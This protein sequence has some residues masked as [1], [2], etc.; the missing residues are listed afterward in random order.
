[1]NLFKRLIFLLPLLYLICSCQSNTSKQST[2]TKALLKHS[3]IQDSTKSNALKIAYVGNMGV[4]I[5]YDDNTVIIDGL[6]Q[7]YNKAYVHPTQDMVD[8]L[9]S[10]NFKNFTAIEY[11]LITHIHG[12]HFSGKYAKQYLEQNTNG[13]VVGSSQIKNDIVDFHSKKDSLIQRLIVVPY[14]KKPHVIENSNISITAIQCNHSSPKRHRNTQNFAYLVEINDFNVL[15]VGDTDWDLTREPMTTLGLKAKQIDIAVLPYWLLL[16]NDA[17]E[18]VENQIAPRH[19]IASH[20]PPDFS[21]REQNQL[22]K[23]VSEYYATYKY[24]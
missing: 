21:K 3:Q 18:Q 7:F 15:H 23:Q 19:I 22:A 6:H 10:G 16:E 20:I 12:D 13:I 5:E 14:D 2:Q 17:L 4:C 11:V 9:I 24:W 8:L 1:M